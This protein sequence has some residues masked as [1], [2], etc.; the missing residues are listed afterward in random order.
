MADALTGGY[1]LGFLVAAML[2]LAAVAVGLVVL[3]PVPRV[4]PER[5]RGRAETALDV[6]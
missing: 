5:R 6:L 4:Q 1:R 3:K 2:M